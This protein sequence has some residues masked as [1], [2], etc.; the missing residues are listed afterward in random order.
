MCAQGHSSRGLIWPIFRALATPPGFVPYA[1]Y[2]SIRWAARIINITLGQVLALG[3]LLELL[4]SLDASLWLIDFL[5]SSLNISNNLPYRKV[6]T[7]T[8]AEATLPHTP[9]SKAFRANAESSFNFI[10]HHFFMHPFRLFAANSILVL[11]FSSTR[12][13]AVR[14]AN[15]NPNVQIY[16]RPILRLRSEVFIC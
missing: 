3:L 1:S 13:D 9:L 4:N 2:H 15:Q 7:E 11:G 5:A 12:S 10:Y 16:L 14:N 8:E 6:E